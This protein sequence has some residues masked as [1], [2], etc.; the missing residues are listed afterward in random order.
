LGPPVAIG[1]MR[2]ANPQGIAAISLPVDY[3]LNR[4]YLQAID[5]TTCATTSLRV[6]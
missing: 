4:V 6:L 5:V 3:L 1:A 2:V